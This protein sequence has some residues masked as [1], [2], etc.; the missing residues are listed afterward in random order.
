MT[1]RPA[2]PAMALLPPPSLKLLSARRPWLVSEQRVRW[3]LVAA[4]SLFAGLL[5]F[6]VVGPNGGGGPWLVG[7][8][9][10]RVGLAALGLALLAAEVCCPSFTR[11]WWEALRCTVCAGMVVFEVVALGHASALGGG[12]RPLGRANVDLAVVV[13]LN[14]VCCALLPLRRLH[15]VRIIHGLWGVRRGGGGWWWWWWRGGARGSDTSP[16]SL[17]CTAAAFPP[18]M[19]LAHGHVLCRVPLQPRPARRGSPLYPL[20]HTQCYTHAHCFREGGG[21]WRLPVELGVPSGVLAWFPYP[22]SPF[23]VSPTPFS[24]HPLLPR[25]WWLRCQPRRTSPPAPPGP[26]TTTLVFASTCCCVAWRRRA[27]VRVAPW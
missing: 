23:P 15:A 13:L 9:V 8:V 3:G 14:M 7:A 17:P 25:C 27:S 2:E 21:G 24:P 10:L 4:Y 20:H 22:P 1:T 19:P 5:V 11:Q 18:R 26:T 6:D 16:V 12:D